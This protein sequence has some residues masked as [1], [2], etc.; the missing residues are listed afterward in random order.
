MALSINCNRSSSNDYALQSLSKVSNGLQR[1]NEEALDSVRSVQRV[2]DE[3]L[4]SIRSTPVDAQ[5]EVL[6]QSPS[7]GCL[8]KKQIIEEERLPLKGPQ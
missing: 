3:A 7:F 1:V 8:I 4:E 6:L 2:N 5:P